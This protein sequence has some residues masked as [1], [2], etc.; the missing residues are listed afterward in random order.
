MKPP[1]RIIPFPDF[2]VEILFIIFRFSSSIEKKK[3]FIFFT[4]MHFLQLLFY[5][6]TI[7]IKLLKIICF[8]YF[9]FNYFKLTKGKK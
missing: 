6:E 8:T 4:F 5:G 2:V 7:L 9:I 3:G 1:S